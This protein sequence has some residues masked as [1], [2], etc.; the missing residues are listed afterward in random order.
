MAEKKKYKDYSFEELKELLAQGKTKDFNAL[1]FYRSLLENEALSKEQ[2]VS[3]RDTAH[4]YFQKQFDFLQIKDLSTY[5]KVTLL[6]QEYTKGDEQN[7]VRQIVN[8]QQAI[9]KDKRIKHRN[10]GTYSI[11][12]CCYEWCPYN[13]MMIQ[14][15]SKL[16][17]GS[18]HFDSD[19]PKAS[20]KQKSQQQKSERKHFDPRTELL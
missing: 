15:G 8:N 3:L 17:E 7:L 12:D 4:Q 10:F 6:G 1:G 19:K 13:G 2:A 20:R 5:L 14:Q 9:L 11:H 16:A 18:M